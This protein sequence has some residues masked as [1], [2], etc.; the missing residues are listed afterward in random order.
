MKQISM[1]LF[2]KLY[3][4]LSVHKDYKDFNKRV[5]ILK[6]VVITANISTL[7]S[8]YIGGRKANSQRIRRAAPV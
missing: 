6:C 7:L 4:T 1:L 5:N 8:T 3:L 2:L